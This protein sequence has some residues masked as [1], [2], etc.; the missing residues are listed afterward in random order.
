MATPTSEV[1][2]SVD[3]GP[4]TLS[5]VLDTVS[6][7]FPPNNTYH[8]IELFV[9]STTER[10]NRWKPAVGPSTRVVL[11]GIESDGKLAPWIPSDVNV[12]VYGDS[13]T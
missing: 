8:T 1:Y 5:L 3:Q 10:A 9:K 4:K 11:T 12:L 6:V 13:I 7:V 2:W